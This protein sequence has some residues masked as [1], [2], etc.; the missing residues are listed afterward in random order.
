[1]EVG[2]A[3][4]VNASAAIR[5][6]RFTDYW[7]YEK[8]NINLLSSGKLW[9]GDAFSLASG[10]TTSRNYVVDMPGLIGSDSVTLKIYAAARS[11]GV[12]ANFAV[13]VNNNLVQ[14]VSLPAISGGFLDT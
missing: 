9:L 2:N 11:I 10:G 8:D 12:P 1:M 14:N 13:R 7:V 3:A 6:N 5:V 4:H